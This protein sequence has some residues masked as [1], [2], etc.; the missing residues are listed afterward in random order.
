MSLCRC[1][2]YARYYGGH[3]QDA[4]DVNG[5]CAADEVGKEVGEAAYGGYAYYERDRGEA[6]P[7]CRIG[8]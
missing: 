1:S 3:T 2:S 4:E 6:F 8:E 5:E 7:P